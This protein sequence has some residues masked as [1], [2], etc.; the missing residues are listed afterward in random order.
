[1][2]I[3]LLTF[4][5]YNWCFFYFILDG[6]KL[7]FLNIRCLLVVSYSLIIFCNSGFKVG[8]LLIWSSITFIIGNSQNYLLF[9]I[10]LFREAICKWLCLITVGTFSLV[11]LAKLFSPWCVFLWNQ[12]NLFFWW[13]NK[14]YFYERPNVIDNNYEC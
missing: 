9:H 8:I 5:G 1:M 10:Q 14:I 3:N 13:K 6:W 12:S 2:K 4:S 11:L 7:L